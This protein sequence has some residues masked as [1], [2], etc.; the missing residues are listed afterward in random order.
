MCIEELENSVLAFFVRR[1]RDRDE[2]DGA[3]DRCDSVAV[4]EGSIPRGGRMG[5]AHVSLDPRAQHPPFRVNARTP[6]LGPATCAC[7]RLKSGM[8]TDAVMA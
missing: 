1:R 8:E 5:C 6:G 7:P 2:L 4:H 3:L